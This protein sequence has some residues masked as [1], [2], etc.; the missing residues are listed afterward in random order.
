LRERSTDNAGATGKDFHRMKRLGELL[1]L[2][3]AAAAF[4]AAS[5]ASAD[6]WALSGYGGWNGSFNS[7]ARFT[8]PNTDWTVSNVPWDGVSFV[9]SGGAPY[10]GYRLTYW[11]TALHNIGFAIDYTHAKIRAVRTATVNYSGTINGVPQNGSAQIQN[12]FDVLEYTDGL[13]LIT[14]NGLYN[15]QPYGPFH[16]YIGA[17]IGIS[18]PHVEVTGHGIVPFQRTF[19]YEFGGP[20]LQVLVGVDVPVTTR[21]SLFGEYKLSWTST[22]S[23][24]TGGYRIHTNVTTNHLLAGATFK[25]GK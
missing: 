16:P 17:G 4:F 20:A 6:V 13:S 15:L 19:A 25:F 12:L 7:D 11:P 24:L 9:K 1:P 18:I 5:P 22:N 21:L 8:G 2:A 14:V 3:L 23:P 10:Y